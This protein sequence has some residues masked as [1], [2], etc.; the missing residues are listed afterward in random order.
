M[1][2]TAAAVALGSV[3]VM[4]HFESARRWPLFSP[5]NAKWVS[6]EYKPEELISFSIEDPD[7]AERGIVVNESLV[8]INDDF[9]VREDQEFSIENYKS[10]DVPMNRA[11]HGDYARLSAA[12]TEATGDKLYVMSSYRSF[13]DQSV[14]FEEDP[15]VA[16]EPGMSEHHSGLALDVYVYMFAGEGFLKSDAGKYVN[17]HCDE[18]GFIIRYPKGKEAITGFSYEPW[19]IRYVGLPHA[20]YIARNNL[21]LEEYIGL[22]DPGEYFSYDGYVVSRQSGPE[23]KVPGDATGVTVSEDNTGCYVITFTDG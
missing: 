21:T 18:F 16:A 14:L 22:F 20:R 8:L 6:V 23:L 3:W 10:T 5:R 12:V 9:P 7:L 2:I 4:I 13:D 15:E 19:H 1:A 11:M 17:E